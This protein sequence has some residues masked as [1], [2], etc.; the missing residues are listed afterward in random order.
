M[1]VD[2]RV[3]EIQGARARRLAAE[4][5]MARV[6]AESGRLADAIPRVL[7]A[8]CTTL[9]WEH[10]ALWQVDR[11]A[12]RL[13]CVDVW[14]LTDST[15]VDFEVL[16]R[17]TTFERGVGLP[18]RVWATAKPAFIPDVAQ[19]ANFPRASTAA[20]A[21]LHAALGFPISVHGDVVGV[22][23][24]FSREIREPDTELLNML[25]TIGSQIGQF[26][27]R[28]RAEEELDR[29]FA[30]SID[31]L[32]IAGFDG[33][34]KR[35]NP[36]WERVLGHS[37]EELCRVPYLDFVHPDDRAATVGA[38]DKVAAGSSV[39]SFENRYR[40]ADGSYR[41]LVW[42]AVPYADERSIYAAAR[43]VT[44][45][46]AAAEQLAR[47]ARD[48][49]RARE[50]EAENADR[51]SQLVRELDRA[52]AKA[53]EA[54]HAKADFLANMS[55]EIRTPMAA[56]IGMADLAMNTKLTSEQREYV[57]TISTQANELLAV[58]NDILDFSKVEARK[59]ALESITFALR[60]T[61]E[62]TMKVLAVRAQQ[63]G[64]ELA[65]HVRSEVPDR[66]MG[67]PGRLKQVL[68]NLVANAIKF[69]ERGEVVVTVELASIEQHAV[70][71]H[72]AVA[73]TGIGISEA[74]RS[75]IFE[76]FVQADTSTTRTFGGT[77]L[78]LSIATELV[79][80]FG[81]TMWL[82]SEVGRGSTFHFTA[83]FERPRDVD[84]AGPVDAAVDLHRLPVLVVD[85]NATNRRILT[86]VLANWKMMPQAVDSGARGLTMLREAQKGK[87]PYAIVIV[88]GQMPEMDGFTFAGRVRHDRRLRSTPLVMLTS[89]ARP[90]D[91]ARCR[92]L[93]M[94]HVSKPVKQSDLL[95]TLLSILGARVAG[96]GPA[97]PSMSRNASRRLRVLVAEDNE[98]NR[99]F[100]TR[101]LQ[102]RG[103]T[104]ATAAN[105][106]LAMEA[107]E[108]FKPKTFDVVLMDVQMP[109]LDG[110]SATVLIRQAE[111]APGGHLGHL[112][113]VAMTAHAMAGDRDRCIAAG[114]DA[115]VT[116]PLHPHEILETVEH[117]VGQA[118]S[119]ATAS[120]PPPMAS[121]MV[122][123]RDE[124]RV[125]LG[126]DRRLLQEVITIFKAELP[127]L[128]TAIR[129]S[130]KNGDTEGLRRAA[131]TL[132]GSLGLL[133]APRAFGSARHLEDV[134][135]RGDL[136][137]VG[138]ATTDLERE[139]DELSHA[140]APSGRKKILKRKGASHGAT[141]SA[142][143]PRTRRRR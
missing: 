72:F 84:T 46:K 136:A 25:G 22:M 52:K 4:Y 99:R 130:A 49:D 37:I 140:L 71:L 26:M 7:K 142:G 19:D 69:T 143:R 20:V 65:S 61:V 89:A 27:E 102:K 80:L 123:D 11:H 43:D 12:N 58:I 120:P 77:G 92:T 87:R 10:G 42:A 118:G 93:K 115:Y 98:V 45:Y 138:P 106:K 33:Y 28:R 79:S 76:A 15:F 121:G 135:R 129:K 127:G 34:F 44:E 78:G 2:G 94:S 103:H 137:N 55:H 6:M 96:G 9:R 74:K 48:L 39:L 35:L 64:L 5:A 32:C 54:A 81:G 24:F 88:D 41:W 125:R 101:V 14:H 109:E 116:K 95:D 105:G 3:R 75:H 97:R 70:M 1:K 124:A 108:R 56:I 30:L 16:S 66:L 8:I 63:R 40:A 126:E 141:R 53:E 114:M 23:E 50:A 110:L 117:I 111:R 82:D 133:G 132:K 62:D 113:I 67:D 31:P 17:N 18:G 83:R 131:H 51:L 91:A 13:R 134:V 21:K 85:D 60:D 29:F 122:F 139:I 112:P 90:T 86:E 36:A 38:A 73:D 128:M 107:I 47:N 104:V 119:S 59:L 100:V 68:T 57:T